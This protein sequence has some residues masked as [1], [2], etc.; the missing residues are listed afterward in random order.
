MTTRAA[1]SGLGLALIG[2]AL[3]ALAGSGGGAPREAEWAQASGPR[4]WVFPA[5][6]GA[7]PEFRTEWWYF[8]GMLSDSAGGEYGYQL[9]FFRR[10]LRFEPAVPANPWSVR[11]VFFAHLAVT[12]IA[13]KRFRMSERASRPGPGLAGSSSEGLDLHLLGWSA[14]MDQGSVRL[15]ASGDGIVL[16]LELEATRPVVLHGAN[17]LSRKGPGPGQASYY[18]SLTRIGTRGV[19]IPGPEESAIPVRGTSW[20]D[21]EFGS[22]VLPAE[23]AGW[24]WMSLGLNDGRDLMVFRL[25]RPDGTDVPGSS[26]ATLIGPGGKVRALAG[27]DFAWDVLDRWKSP[28][29]GAD[30]PRR[31]RFRIPS[32]GIDVE[33]APLVDGQELLTPGSTRVT[34][35][36]GAVSALGVSEG[37][38]V[39]GRGYVE[40]T[41]YAGRL[42]GVF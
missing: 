23:A 24:D 25:R 14:K 8:T 38:P 6:H 36:E 39:R 16:D 12:D 13:R 19:L 10:G 31:R 33:I 32:F 42:G 22:G 15:R 29:S 30:Y 17:G 28:R 18:S 35:W 2:A 3:L 7:H 27:A 21:H 41:G 5:D 20:F 40:M 4:K 11:D 34:Y 37:R 1:K 9:T 26:A